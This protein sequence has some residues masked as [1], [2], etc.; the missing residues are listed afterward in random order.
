MLY[1]HVNGDEMAYIDPGRSIEP[2]QGIRPSQ[3]E[4]LVCVQG[5]LADSR[6]WSPVLGQADM[7]RLYGVSE[8]TV[9][10][11]VAT[12]LAGQASRE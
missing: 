8:Y 2:G 11:I 10:R 12:H 4:P 7:A 1:R 9:V 5:P 3:S 6:V